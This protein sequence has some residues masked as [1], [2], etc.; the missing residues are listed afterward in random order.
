MLLLDEPAAGLDTSDSR[1]LGAR[2]RQLRD[3]GVAILLVDHDLE[4]I[5]DLC[6]DVQVLDFGELIAS[7]TPEAVRKDQRVRTAYIGSEAISLDGGADVVSGDQE[8]Q[9]PVVVP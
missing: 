1:R 3:Q 5:L 2:L 6:D 9:S 4:L 8:G 7:G